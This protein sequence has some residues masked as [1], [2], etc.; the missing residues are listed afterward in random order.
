MRAR[1]QAASL[2]FVAW[3]VIGNFVL[4]TLFLA[5]LIT[6]FTVSHGAE[7]AR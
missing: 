6:N 7:T 5:I 4:M 3:I 1:G 2:Y